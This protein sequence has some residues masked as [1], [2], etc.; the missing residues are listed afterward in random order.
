[1][2]EKQ[3]TDVKYRENLI[4]N[5]LYI[6][7]N[8]ARQK[9]KQLF[10]YGIRN[11]LINEIISIGYEGLYKAAVI[12]DKNKN[13]NFYGFAWYHIDLAF[14]SYQRNIDKLHHVTRKKI[15]NINQ[16]SDAL[17][18][19]LGR[20]PNDTEIAGRLQIDENDLRKYKNVELNY[21]AVNQ[22]SD[23]DF[24]PVDREYPAD[25]SMEKNE[26]EFILGRDM[27]DCLENTLSGVQRK[28]VELMY[29]DNL[30]AVKIADKLWGKFDQKK[31]NLIYNTTKNGKIKLKK[32]MEKKGWSITDIA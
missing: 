10:S 14:K 5:N 30:D 12:F 25:I 7:E 24:D 21:T 6:L 22:N 2:I 11:I 4:N 26:R 32:C 31:K 27:N 23:E 28:I 8:Y 17:T 18:Q 20:P 29:L 19:E 16:I 9:Y 3:E 1:M 15:K 13:N